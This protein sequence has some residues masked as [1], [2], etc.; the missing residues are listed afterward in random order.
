VPVVAGARPVGGS[1]TQVGD[2][3]GAVPTAAARAPERPIVAE[4][5]PVRLRRLQGEPIARATRV[6]VSGEGRAM[7]EVLTHPAAAAD[8]PRARPPTLREWR[9][10]SLQRAA[11]SGTPSPVQQ[12]SF[13]IRLPEESTLPRGAGAG[14]VPSPPLT[15]GAQEPMPPSAE[16]GSPVPR[17]QRAAASGT[18]E[19][20]LPFRPAAPRSASDVARPPQRPVPG[21]TA[22]EATSGQ[23]VAGGTPLIQRRALTPRAAEPVAVVRRAPESASA[24]AADA[25]A[26]VELPVA[27]A[28]EA[29]PS[30][31]VGRVA[32]QVYELLVSRLARERRQ[33]GW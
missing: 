24:A 14:A 30:V 1:T 27:T 15:G 32:D 33:R 25:A 11:G 19:L 13:G 5:G 10:Q 22:G 9:T 23:G 6:G 3:G 20:R 4:T 2:S 8:V 7:P 16:P 26:D 18:P 17:L 28:A 31:D 29:T 21:M 12:Q